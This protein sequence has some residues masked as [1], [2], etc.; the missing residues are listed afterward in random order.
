MESGHPQFQSNF[1]ICGFPFKTWGHWGCGQRLDDEL[2]VPWHLRA[3]SEGAWAAETIC[4]ALDDWP[5]VSLHN[6]MV[7]G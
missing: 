2:F 1:W 4:R 6:A 3:E 7:N 5:L